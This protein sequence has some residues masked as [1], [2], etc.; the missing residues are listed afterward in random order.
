MNVAILGTEPPSQIVAQI[1]EQNYNLWLEHQ[2]K[3]K[4]NVVTYVEG[5]VN[6]SNIGNIPILNNGCLSDTYQSLYELAH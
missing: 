1:I 6:T 5:S 2:G 4:L 3:E